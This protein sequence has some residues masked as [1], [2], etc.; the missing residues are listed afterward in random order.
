M[1]L[2]IEQALGNQWAMFYHPQWPVEDLLPGCTLEQSVSTT[3]QQLQTG[4]IINAWPYAYQDEIARLLWV[5][6][7]YQRLNTEPIRKPV[8]VHE[9]DGKLLVNCGDTRLMSLKLLS[10]PGTV[11]VLVTVPQDQ[12]SKYADWRQIHTN[13]DLIRATGFSRSANIF[14]RAATENYA[15]EW[16]E[17]GDH[18][19]AHHL[20][21]VDQRVAMMQRYIDTQEDTFEFSVDWARSYINW[22]IYAR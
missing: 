3:N 19:T 12:N 18:T 16:L 6:W 21:D 17:I 14:L 22:D 2:T 9:Q 8:L 10:D 15:I 20:H 7:M 1:E 5:N 13:R 4:R 11:G